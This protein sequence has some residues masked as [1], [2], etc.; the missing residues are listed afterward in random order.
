MDHACK[1][2][3]L[4]IGPKGIISHSGSDGSTPFQRLDRYGQWN[5]TAGENLEFGNNKGR[6]IIIA[7][8]VD[9][10]VP[11]RGH[12]AN[13]FKEDFHK[14]GISH[15]PHSKSKYMTCNVFAGDYQE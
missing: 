1:D 2:H 14:T 7:L 8:I 4:D 15:G 12:R 10:G 5:Y 3:V 11:D 13:I 6:D 9:D